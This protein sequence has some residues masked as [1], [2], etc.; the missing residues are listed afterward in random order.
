MMNYEL[1][2]EIKKIKSIAEIGLQYASS[3]YETERYT[4]LQHI[5]Y[6]LLSK[7]SDV[8]IERLKVSLP[9]A[10]D[11]PTAKVDIRG[12]LLTEDNKVLLVRE[13][14]DGKWSLPGGWADVGLTPKE[15]VTKEF[16]EET[17]LDVEVKSLLA[18][19]DKKMH[20]HPPQAF[21]VYKMV[22]LCKAVSSEI[23]KGFDVLDVGYFSIADLP[24]L[25]ENRILRSQIEF[26]VDRIQRGDQTAHFD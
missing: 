1:L 3:G 20:P 5:S 11:Y 13:S 12:L 9:T 25:S 19:F 24:E 23:V 10:T 8:P 18:V 22:F 14:A 7:I 26:V 17:G 21:Y 15:V 6:T 2:E 16:K 4:E